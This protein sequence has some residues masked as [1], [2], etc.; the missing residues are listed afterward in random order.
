MG[1]EVLGDGVI[2]VDVGFLMFLRVS[3]VYKK[4]YLQLILVLNINIQFN[5]VI[6]LKFEFFFKFINF[7]ILYIILV[8]F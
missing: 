3:F 6:G 2:I 8:K 7:N 5:K 1:L 4:D